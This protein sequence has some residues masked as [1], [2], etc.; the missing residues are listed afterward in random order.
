MSASEFAPAKINLALHVRRREADGYHALETLFVFADVGD[1]VRWL[2]EADGFDLAL[3]GRFAGALEHDPDNLVLLAAR[4]LAQAAGVRC[5]ARLT[6]DKMLPVASGLGGGSADAAA[7]LRLLNRVWGLAWPVARLA[8]LG[9]MLGADVPACVRSVPMRGEGR[10]ERL[11]PIAFAGAAVVLVNPGVAVST[12]AVF[13]AWD[14]VD[15]GA[16]DDGNALTAARTG[17]N[18]LELPARAIAPAIDGAL[19]LL[20]AQPGAGLVRMSGS[21][22]TCFGLF[23]DELRAA[24]GGRAIAAAQPGW[25]VATGNLLPS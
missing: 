6:L 4:A 22:A 10:G 24:A 8:D 19:A 25:W 20:A 3:E 2:G 21:G 16:L 11:G 9:A 17:R 5:G 15:R 14:G 18:D 23:A 12:A 13:G 1:T 7:A